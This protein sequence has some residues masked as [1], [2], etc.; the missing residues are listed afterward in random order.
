MTDNALMYAL[1]DS[2]NRKISTGHITSENGARVLMT[3]GIYLKSNSSETFKVLIW[4]QENG[5]NQDHE[6]GK[7]FVGGFDITATQIKYK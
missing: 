7:T 4:L 3:S 6:E 5:Q 1:Y 2:T